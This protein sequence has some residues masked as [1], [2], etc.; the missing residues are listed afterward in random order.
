VKCFII[1]VILKFELPIVK[2]LAI[3][4]LNS[5]QAYLL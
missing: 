4:F 2:I 3:I 5:F 1:I